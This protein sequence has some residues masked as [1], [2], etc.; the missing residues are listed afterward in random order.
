MEVL[1][2]WIDSLSEERAKEE[3][4]SLHARYEERG[5]AMRETG[6]MVRSL[7]VPKVTK[8]VSALKMAIEYLEPRLASKT[9]SRGLT[10]ILPA[11]KETLEET[12]H[13]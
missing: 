8:L 6:D 9:G 5:M 10:V 13:G 2:K 1:H 11:L 4:K 12:K 3:L 7:Y